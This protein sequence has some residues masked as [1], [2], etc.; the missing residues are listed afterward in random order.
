MQVQKEGGGPLGHRRL[1]PPFGRRRLG[2][3]PFGR[4]KFGRRFPFFFSSYEEK[5]MKQAIP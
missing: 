3:V 1:V 5:R 2:A 4:R